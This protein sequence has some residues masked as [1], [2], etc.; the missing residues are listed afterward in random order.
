MDLTDNLFP[1]L[2]PGNWL[3]D[4][5]E[6]PLMDQM[7][8]ADSL[9][10]DMESD[11]SMDSAVEMMTAH[12]Q[13]RSRAPSPSGEEYKRSWYST[14]PK[15]HVYDGDVINILLNLSKTHISSTFAIFSDFE[16]NSDTRAELWLAMAAV[17]GLYCTVYS[18]TNVAKMLFNDSRRLLLEQYLQGDS[19]SFDTTLSFAKTFILLEIYGLCSGDKRAYEFVEVFHGSKLDAGTPAAAAPVILGRGPAQPSCCEQNDQISETPHRWSSLCSE[20]Q[21]IA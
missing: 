21:S 15:L 14:P 12:L 19:M 9:E 5:N 7:W 20:L 6:F 18:G 2:N 16:A 10:S 8:P 3:D 1:Q 17:G 13:R 4:L 11:P